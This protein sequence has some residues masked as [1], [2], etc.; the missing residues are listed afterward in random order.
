M[1]TLAPAM[2]LAACGGVPEP[3]SDWQPVSHVDVGDVCFEADGDDITVRVV[4]ED[5][6][7]SGCAR[8]FV[9]DCAATV[10]GTDITLTSS[11]EWETYVGDMA[12]PADCGVPMVECTVSGLADGSYTVSF[13]TETLSL[14]IP[15][16]ESCS[17]F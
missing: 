4:V 17:I 7:S 10:D 9:G 3:G 16:V 1:R 15:V 8:D 11:M 6:M 5:C 2:I 12:C 14:E 13:G